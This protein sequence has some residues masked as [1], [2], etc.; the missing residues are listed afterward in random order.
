MRCYSNLITCGMILQIPV[1]PTCGMLP[2][3]MGYSYSTHDSCGYLWEVAPKGHPFLVSPRH[4]LASAVA[5]PPVSTRL[6]RGSSLPWR[7]CASAS[8]GWGWLMGFGDDRNYGGL[9]H[10]DFMGISLGEW[11]IADYTTT[12]NHIFFQI[13]GAAV[14]WNL[15]IFW[16]KMM[17][18]WIKQTQ[19]LENKPFS[20]G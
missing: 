16:A 11:L 5:S 7:N 8:C 14:W 20:C 15:A 1:I 9:P 4:L 18:F 10:W 17:D 6:C 3:L 19:H 12:T 2:E 13:S